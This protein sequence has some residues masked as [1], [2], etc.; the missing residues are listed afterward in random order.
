MS[1][2]ATSN[3]TNVRNH[4]PLLAA[5]RLA[6][7]RVS[8]AVASAL[9]P[10]KAVDTAARLFSTPRDMRKPK[11]ESTLALHALRVRV[12]FVS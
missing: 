11:G 4:S 1:Q 12:G 3:S 5:G 2:I 9:A 6:W 8:L 10:E 7:H